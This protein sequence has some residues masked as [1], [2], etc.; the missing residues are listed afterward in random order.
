MLLAP[1]PVGLQGVHAAAEI[2]LQ[3]A[4]QE[5]AASAADLRIG[6]YEPGPKRVARRQA[7][8]FKLR[9]RLAP[10]CIGVVTQ[11]S[12]ECCGRLR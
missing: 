11:L 12:H 1:F 4:G 10:L 9:G 7:A 3:H 5:P 6:S 2:R 8:L